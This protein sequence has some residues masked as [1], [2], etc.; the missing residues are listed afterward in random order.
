MTP[1]PSFCCNYH[2]HNPPLP[3]HYHTLP[4]GTV[5]AVAAL[6][7][8]SQ[9]VYTLQHCLLTLCNLLLEDENQLAVVQQG[10]LSTLIT[11]SHHENITIKDFSSL[12]F[13]N[14]SLN[15]ESRKS[16]VIAGA[17]V[18]II[19]LAKEKSL[20]TKTR[21]AAALMNLATITPAHIATA[22]LG[23]LMDRMINDG[24]IPGT[25]LMPPC[26]SSNTNMPHSYPLLHFFTR[27]LTHSLTHS[28]T[29]PLTHPLN[30]SSL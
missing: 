25:S 13:L 22:G 18:A 23:N 8:H 28:Q 15:D 2:D 24:I 5:P 7:K 27:L 26:T 1:P 10:L 29:H 6:L 20:V 19:N 14:L 4:P 21:C 11:L 16:A 3:T 12:A 17:V 30:K 9:D